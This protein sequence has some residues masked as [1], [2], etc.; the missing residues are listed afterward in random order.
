MRHSK[1]LHLILIASGI[2]SRVLSEHTIIAHFQELG[3]SH[4]ISRE[5]DGDGK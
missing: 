5:H 1:S 2:N 3:V 4:F